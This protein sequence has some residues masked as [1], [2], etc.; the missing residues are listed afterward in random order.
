MRGCYVPD[1]VVQHMIPASRLNK[2]YFRRWF[3]WRGISRAQLY[4]RWG[5]DL[6]VPEQKA[7]DPSLVPHIA[8]VPRYLY[9]KALVSLGRWAKASLRRDAVVAF[10][11]ELWIW[12]FAGIVAERWKEWRAPRAVTSRGQRRP[13]V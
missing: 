4:E 2:N 12:F 10:E 1:M 7:L 8:G 9:R 11:H 5:F 13:A 6:Q 3:Y